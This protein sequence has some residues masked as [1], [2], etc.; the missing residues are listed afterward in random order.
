MYIRL[1]KEGYYFDC[2]KKVWAQNLFN[3]NG[4]PVHH[5][6]DEIDFC[7][8]NDVDLAMEYMPNHLKTLKNIM[9]P[10][11][12]FTD[13]D[14]HEFGTHRKIYSWVKMDT[15]K[16]DCRPD[17]NSLIRDKLQVFPED[18]SWKRWETIDV[19]GDPKIIY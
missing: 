16:Y 7:S 8:D 14:T 15:R 1:H 2:R 3:V 11:Y 5:L 19:E 17:P 12:R 9:G 10:N 18:A 4:D 13:Y 6:P